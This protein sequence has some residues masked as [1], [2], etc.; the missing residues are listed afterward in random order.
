MSE[1]SPIKDILYEQIDSISEKRIQE[2]ISKNNT[3]NMIREVMDSCGPKIGALDGNQHG[4]FEAFAESLMHY[5]LTNALIQS[6][7]KVTYN[8]A[9][10][11]IIIPD[12]R[13]LISSPS[14]ALIIVFPKTDNVGAILESLRKIEAVQPIKEN[15]WLI[16]KTSLGIDHKTYE[17]DGSRSFSNIINDI[18]GFLSSKK[19]SKLKIFK[20]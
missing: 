3:T 19:Q 2:E 13:T 11:D 14:D 7:R 8:S 16:Q 17:I 15:I 20:V 12:V 9:E 1:S 18:G 10:I 5:L 4:N 6:Q